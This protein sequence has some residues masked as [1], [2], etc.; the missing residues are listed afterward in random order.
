MLKP[1]KGILYIATGKEF[2]MEAKVSAMRVKKVMPKTKIDIA[3]D[4]EPEYA[5]FDNW[6]EVKKPSRDFED[7][8]NNL[9]KSRF[10]KTLFLDTD[11]YVNTKIDDI[12]ELT[13]EFDIAA[14]HNQSRS[15]GSIDPEGVP[16][17]FPE[18]NTGVI[19]YKSG[20]KFNKFVDR[21]RDLN[22]VVWPK[23]YPQPAFRKALYES[24]LRIA[25]LRPEDNLMLRYPGYVAEEARIL[26]G[27]LLDIDTPGSNVRI[28]PGRAA[29]VINSSSRMR[30]Y[31]HTQYLDN[32]IQ[33]YEK[34][35]IGIKEIV[36]MLFNKF[37]RKMKK[38]L[39]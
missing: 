34:F 10:D 6:I 24:D 14:A 27:R 37:K 2:M 3:S 18:Y 22:E 9:T 38:Y 16:T 26:H 31:M 20:N 11:I 4:I 7:K 13:N 25:T 36:K 12:F 19:A 15:I 32:K 1:T 28:D 17:S 8:I 33:V 23:G 5:V 21:W 35:D 30:V 39:M 29:K